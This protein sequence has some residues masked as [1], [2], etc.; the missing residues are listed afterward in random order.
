LGSIKKFDAPI[1]QATT[2]SLEALKAFS[3]ANDLRSQGHDLEAIPVYKRA[4]EI[5]PN[6]AV[7]YAR[8]AVTYNNW[9]ETE[10]AKEYSQKAYEL[11]DRVSEREKFY[12]SE[13]YHTYV[14][15]NRDEAITH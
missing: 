14:T 11:R 6:F 3:Q 10:L 4:I 2:S 5:D 15:G 1:D 9:G 13:K 8:L 7:A 12:I